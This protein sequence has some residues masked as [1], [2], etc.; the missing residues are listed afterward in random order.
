M[1]NAMICVSIMLA[2]FLGWPL[3]FG[4]DGD[5]GYRPQLAKPDAAEAAQPLRAETTPV[6]AAAPVSAPVQGPPESCYKRYQ[7]QVRT[8]SNGNGA[9]CRLKAADNWDLCEAT[10][11]WPEA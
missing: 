7:R 3:A 6:S 8:C 9:A 1:R 4:G 10:G 5:A 11:F 2:V